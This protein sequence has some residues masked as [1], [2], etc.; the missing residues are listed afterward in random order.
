M[1]LKVLEYKHM[2]KI[3]EERN[4]VMETLRTSMYLNNDMQKEYYLN[5]ICNRD[6]K[7][8]YFA[9]YEKVNV[10]NNEKSISQVKDVFIGM[11]GIET[12]EWENGRG[13][14]S[15]LIFEEYR[16]KGYGKHAVR[17]FL[18]N[19]FN[20]FGLSNVWLLCYDCNK[21][22]IKFWNMILDN[23]KGYKTWIPAAKYYKGKYYG[24]LYG[25]ISKEDF[26]G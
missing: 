11:G 18:D 5:T 21:V 15:L 22:G 1:I 9:L 19:A 10:F 4:K 16:K 20:Y 3:I 26:N 7:T 13:E 12:I 8:R 24:A 6:S 25:N 23:Y 14:L 17:M 2:A